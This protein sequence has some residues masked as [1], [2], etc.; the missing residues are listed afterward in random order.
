MQ[1]TRRKASSSGVPAAAAPRPATGPRALRGT[2]GRF[3]AERLE[4]VPLEQVVY[5]NEAV[6]VGKPRRVPTGNSADLRTG[7]SLWLHHRL[8]EA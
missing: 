7:Q 1:S 2:A 6:A 5:D 3:A 4:F 8:P